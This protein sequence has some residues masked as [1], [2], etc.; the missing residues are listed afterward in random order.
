MMNELF[1]MENSDL[2]LQIRHNIRFLEGL[3]DIKRNNKNTLQYAVNNPKGKRYELIPRIII[4]KEIN[5]HK[6]YLDDIL[7]YSKD[8]GMRLYDFNTKESKDECSIF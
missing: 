7:D 2:D 4:L 1:V 8:Y 6:D 5:Y 3:L